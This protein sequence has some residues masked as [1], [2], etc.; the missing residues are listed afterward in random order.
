MINCLPLA[1]CLFLQP[2]FVQNPDST[3]GSRS[4][5]AASYVE[6]GNDW[7]KKGNFESAISDY[8]LAIAFDGSSPQA[9][10]N[11]GLARERSGDRD[12][13][14]RD[15][16]KALQLNPRLVPA[17]QSRGILRLD[18]NESQPLSP[19]S[20]RRL[21]FLRVRPRSGQTVR[22]FISAPGIWMPRLLTALKRS[23]LTSISWRPGATGA[24]RDMQKEISRVRSRIAIRQS[25]LIRVTQSPSTIEAAFLLTLAEPK[26]QFQIS[27]GRSHSI[28]QEVTSTP[29]AARLGTSPSNSIKRMRTSTARLNSTRMK[30]KHGSREESSSR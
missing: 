12:G 28:R 11:R 5:S 2:P 4:Q 6:R 30:W 24:E 17:L 9:F 3:Q 19:I 27:T 15:F 23:S 25:R 16:E 20:I 21:K 7:L 1:L 14:L 22:V 18:L 13:A 10:Y 26:K 8:S 29:T